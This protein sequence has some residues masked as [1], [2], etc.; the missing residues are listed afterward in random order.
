MSGQPSN[1][2]FR[3][4]FARLFR[5][6]VM[7]LSANAYAQQIAAALR[8]SYGDSSSAAKEI[9]NDIGAGL[10]TVRKWLAGENGPS[11]EH[12]L[13]LMAQRD[14]VWMR[15][16]AMTERDDGNNEQRERMRRALAILEGREQ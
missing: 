5:G 10:G 9:A 15:V 13:K 1:N 6:G 12:L 11:G 3:A 8:D 4:R 16:L 7:E 14:A 2:N